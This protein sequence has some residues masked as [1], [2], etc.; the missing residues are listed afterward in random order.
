MENTAI[1]DFDGTIFNNGL[2]DKG[3]LKKIKE[4]FHKI[5]I[6]S[7]NSS[8]SQIKIESFVRPFSK[9]IITPQILVKS[10]FKREFVEFDICC[11][12]NVLNYLRGNNYSSYKKI[13]GIIDQFAYDA[14][15]IFLKEKLLKRIGILGKVDFMESKKF[16]DSCISNQY[17]L[18]GMNLDK[19]K[20]SLG[21][22]DTS[23]LVGDFY[24]FKYDFGKTSKPYIYFLKNYIRF[25]NLK[26]L[27]IFGD[28]FHSDGLLAESLS[29]GYEK[30][31]FGKSEFSCL[32]KASFN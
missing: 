23:D 25:F 31:I 6:V 28:N 3:L 20:D 26:P 4:E 1:V 32:V 30:I 24:P 13:E 10:I 12:D 11:S 19:S 29:I 15:S 14:T 22:S 8:I 18:I 5:L 21:I 27:V 17:T 9:H 7:N 2:L 16:I